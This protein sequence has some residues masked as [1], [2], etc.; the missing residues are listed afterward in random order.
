MSYLNHNL[1]KML[2][3]Q[4]NLKNFQNVAYKFYAFLKILIHNDHQ[5]ISLYYSFQVNL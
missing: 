3:E 4:K 2:I 5:N 1:A